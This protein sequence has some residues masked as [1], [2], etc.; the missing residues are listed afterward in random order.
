MAVSILRLR[1]RVFRKK[2][3]SYFETWRGKQGPGSLL[4]HKATICDVVMLILG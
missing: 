2:T 4:V 3:L 1:V